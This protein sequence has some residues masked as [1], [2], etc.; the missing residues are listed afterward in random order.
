MTYAYPSTVSR[1]S[2]NLLPTAIEWM[3]LGH[4]TIHDKVRR[5][6]KAALVAGK[7]DGGLR[8][9]N[10]LTEPPS[11]EMNLSAVTLRLIVA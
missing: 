8:L 9:F 1:A 4:S 6:D 7:E 5:I 2:V 10:G 11:G 3:N